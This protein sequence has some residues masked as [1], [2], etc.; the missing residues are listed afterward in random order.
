MLPA[1]LGIIQGKFS[2]LEH[3]IP[4]N[5]PDAKLEIGS[6]PTETFESRVNDFP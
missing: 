2:E 1:S 3:A 4:S 6:G 5:H